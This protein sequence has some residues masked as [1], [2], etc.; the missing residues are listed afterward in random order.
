[1][2]SSSI[3]P[4]PDR[5]HVLIVDDDPWIH[6]FVAAAA[7][8]EGWAVSTAFDGA[9]ALRKA[10]RQ[11]PSVIV[12]DVV[13]PRLDGW[14]LVRELRTMAELA[15][16]P[17][18]FLTGEKT[19]RDCNRG[20]Q[21]GADAYLTKPVDIEELIVAIKKALLGR[22]RLEERYL[23]AAERSELGELRG[24]IE[25]LGISWILTLL[26]SNGAS[27]VIEVSCEEPRPCAGV[28]YLQDGTIQAATLRRQQEVR[29]LDALAA[30]MSWERGTYVFSACP[31]DLPAEMELS[32]QEA[33][34]EL[35]RRSME[36]CAP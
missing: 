36:D 14:S 34:L 16:I 23:S 4:T 19:P 10:L 35:A 29:N 17:V 9:A 21:M 1:V 20:F 32:T 24:R 3:P 27:G 18:V 15:T 13:M 8:C 25:D 5:V 6:Q 33:L 28:I 31:V 12:T 30:M 2:S 11:P 22:R 7:Q 26:D